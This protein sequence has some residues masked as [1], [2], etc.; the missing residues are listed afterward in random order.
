MYLRALSE[1]QA[2]WGPLLA[3]RVTVLAVTSG[4]RVTALQS[5]AVVK[6]NRVV[7]STIPLN[8]L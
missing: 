4:I 8:F 5:E 7:K 1:T 6:A 2:T 3:S